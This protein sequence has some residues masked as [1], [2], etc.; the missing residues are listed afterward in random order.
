M[1]PKIPRASHT[2]IYNLMGYR[3]ASCSGKSTKTIFVES[4][5]TW[6]DYLHRNAFRTQLLFC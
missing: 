1:I 2:P 6:D 4:V 3:W 5:F